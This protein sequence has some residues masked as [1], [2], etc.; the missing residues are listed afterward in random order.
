MQSPTPADTVADLATEE[1]KYFTVIDA[2][3][4][5]HQ[6]PRKEESQH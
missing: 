6:C 1:V 2:M 4:G 3:K 5:Y